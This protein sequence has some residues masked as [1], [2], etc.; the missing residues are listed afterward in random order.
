MAINYFVFY[1]FMD[2]VKR[3]NVCNNAA[4]CYM[5]VAIKVRC[6]T[7]SKITQSRTTTPSSAESWELCYVLHKQITLPPG[8]NNLPISSFDHFIITTYIYALFHKFMRAFQTHFAMRAIWMS[9]LT[10]Y[11]EVPRVEDECKN[12]LGERASLNWDR[13]PRDEDRTVRIQNV[14]RVQVTTSGECTLS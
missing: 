11:G 13:W 8:S 5:Q 7:D 1:E 12:G 2:R 4:N 14:A 9:L 10:R 6:C 3:Y